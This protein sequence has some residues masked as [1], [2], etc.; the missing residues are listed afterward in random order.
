MYKG[1]RSSWKELT[2]ILDANAKYILDV[3][4]FLLGLITLFIFLDIIVFKC[5]LPT[6]FFPK[7]NIIFTMRFY[8]KHVSSHP[9][10]NVAW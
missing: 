6:L 4:V 7:A 8:R 1:Q 3:F 10:H 9:K 2:V 5:S